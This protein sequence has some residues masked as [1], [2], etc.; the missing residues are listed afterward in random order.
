MRVGTLN[1]RVTI[2]KPVRTPG[3]GGTQIDGGWEDVATVWANVRGLSGREYIQA[4]Q[5]QSIISHQVTIRYRSDVSPHYRLI[6][7]QRQMD[8]ISA[9]DPDGKKV[10]LALMCQEVVE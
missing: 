9:I 7:D 4:Q 2:Q 1:S 3:P 5:A 6:C 8:I 10:Q